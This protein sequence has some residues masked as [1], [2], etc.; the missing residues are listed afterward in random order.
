M[1]NMLSVSTKVLSNAKKLEQEKVKRV[2]EYR[3]QI[4]KKISMANK[5]L[6]RLEK[7]GLTDSPA[8]QR[9]IKDGEPQFSIKGKDYRQVQQEEVRLNRYLDSLTSTVRGTTKHLKTMAKNIGIKYDNMKQL[10]ED[11]KIFF[12]LDSKAKQYLRNVEDMG[13][14]IGYQAVWKE[15]NT[16]MIDFKHKL[17]GSRA[18]VEEMLKAVTDALKEHDKPKFIS[19]DEEWFTLE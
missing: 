12:E 5:R 18:D 1:N 14:A 6:R 19:D 3:A 7:A 8:Y 13:S 15:V 10:Q 17:D 11:A 16:V 9:L 4:T 2:K